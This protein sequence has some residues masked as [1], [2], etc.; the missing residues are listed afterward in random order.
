MVLTSPMGSTHKI[1]IATHFSQR[2]F[3][4]VFRDNIQKSLKPLCIFFSALFDNKIG[5]VSLT[6]LSARFQVMLL[7]IYFN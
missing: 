6:S 7:K 5:G 2:N 1:T 4:G 3:D